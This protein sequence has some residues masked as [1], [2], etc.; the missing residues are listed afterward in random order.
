MASAAA[1]SATGEP[2]SISRKSIYLVAGLVHAARPSI[3]DV[4]SA[5]ATS[6]ARVADLRIKVR[7]RFS[8]ILISILTV[9]MVVPRTVTFEGVV[10]RQ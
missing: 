9:G 8:D 4:L 5:Q 1:T 2:F 7:S 10:V 6:N 3:D